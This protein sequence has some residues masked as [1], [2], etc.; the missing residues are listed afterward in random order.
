LVLI[1]DDDEDILELAVEI[2][3]T[4]GYA[5]LIARNGLGAVAVLRETS[6]ISILFT[7]IQMPS[8][9]G[10]ELAGVTVA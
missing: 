10:E 1:V 9:G 8:M 7:D 3:Q 6:R 2:F 4:L 5:V